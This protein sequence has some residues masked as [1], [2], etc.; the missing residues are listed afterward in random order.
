MLQ[1]SI[2]PMWR[3]LIFWA[4]YCLTDRT[5]HIYHYLSQTQGSRPFS[6]CSADRHAEKRRDFPTNAHEWG[7]DQQDASFEWEA[8]M[9][10]KRIHVH[11]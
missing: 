6:P 8:R 7:T 2:L 10:R 11:R 1:V 3:S 4:V 5:Y 9:R